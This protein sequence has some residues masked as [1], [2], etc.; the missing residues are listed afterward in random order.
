[1]PSFVPVSAPLWAGNEGL[2]YAQSSSIIGD[3]GDP[4]SRVVYRSLASGEERV[5]FWEEELFPFVGQRLDSTSLGVLGADSLIFHTTSTRQALYE[6]SLEEPGIDQRVLTRS[7]GRD[8]QPTYSPDGRGV[9]FSSNRSGNLD[10]WRMDLETGELRQLTDDPGQDYDPGLSPDGETLVWT[11][12]RT[13]NF[14]VWIADADGSGGRQLTRD[15]VDAENPTMAADGEWVVFWSSHPEK[16]GVWKIRPDGSDLSM[17]AK[18]QFANSEVSPDG[19]Y[20]AYLSQRPSN[21]ETL[22]LVSDIERAESVPF[23]IRVA[24]PAVVENIIFGRCRWALDGQSI[25]FVGADEDGRTGIY[26]QAFVPGEDTSATRKRLAGF[27]SKQVV[28]SFGFSP[29]GQ[30]VTLAMLEYT[31][32]LKV[33]DGVRMGL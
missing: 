7:E 5:L 26:E 29:D 16:S 3:D 17:V 24:T 15:G 1:M 32:Q 22:I 11:S 20:V 19:R 31:W 4:L 18:G 28:E 25:A 8:R 27:A 6:Q 30:R 33:A 23:Q 13:G 21:L 2:I 12:D 14:E 9:L 10:L